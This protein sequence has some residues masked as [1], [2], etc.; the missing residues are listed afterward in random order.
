MKLESEKNEKSRQNAENK[1]T[2]DLTGKKNQ[3]ENEKS[4][5]N[6]EKYYLPQSPFKIESTHPTRLAIAPLLAVK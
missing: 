2:F 3:N 4:R 5:Q 6:A 1:Q